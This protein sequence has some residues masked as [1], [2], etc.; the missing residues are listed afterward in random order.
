[1]KTV[2]IYLQNMLKLIYFNYRMRFGEN[3]SAIKNVIKLTNK[4]CEIKQ[5]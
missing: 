5:N 3:D 1:M 4:L 2:S